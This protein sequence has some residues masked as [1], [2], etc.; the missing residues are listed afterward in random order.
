MRIDGVQLQLLASLQQQGGGGLSRCKLSAIQHFFQ[1][2]TIGIR[3]LQPM[4]RI[5]MPPLDIEC[6]NLRRA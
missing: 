3:L 2:I 5:D 1:N 4:P 6:N